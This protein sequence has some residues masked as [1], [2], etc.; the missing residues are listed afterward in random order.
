M[1]QAPV[2]VSTCWLSRSVTDGGQ[3]AR[4]L[5]DIGATAAELDFRLSR[6]TLDQAVEAFA[7]LGVK[8]LSVHAVCPAPDNK[9]ARN[10]A[11]R[12]SISSSDETERKTG[13]EDVISTMR[14]AAGLGASC[15]VVHCGKTPMERVTPALQRMFDEGTLGGTDGAKFINDIKIKRLR[16]RG[17]T[18]EMLMR[19]LSEIA[20]AAEALNVNVGLE[21]RYYMEE[22]PNYEEL[23]VIFQRLE[24]SRIRYWH[25]TGHAQAQENLGLIS[26]E[27]LLK[28]FSG[29][30]EGMHI[31][32]VRGYTDHYAP[33][34]GGVDFG[35]VE[36]YTRP[37]TMRILELRGDVGEREAAAGLEWIKARRTECKP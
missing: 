1:N 13:V 26:H 21:N 35:M 34:A 36:K 32:D 4:R 18:F 27:A 6:A 12:A 30:M 7:R 24:G 16:S 28:E 29:V 37:D 20:E 25:D 31:H 33:P 17:A 3:I 9:T 8:I 23:A 14:L 22:Y 5:K 11:E 2:G 15:V 10:I 19:S